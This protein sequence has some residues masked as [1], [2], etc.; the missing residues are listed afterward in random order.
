MT[1]NPNS[2]R[3]LTADELIAM[4]V[5][6]TGIGSI[7]WWSLNHRP[8]TV[9]NN[10]THSANLTVGDNNIVQTLPLTT[11]QA[12]AKIL[13]TGSQTT[14]VPAP[15]TII[16]NVPVAPAV[17]AAASGAAVDLEPPALAAPAAS[18]LPASV[19]PAMTAVLP[20]VLPSPTSSTPAFTD[21]PDQYWGKDYITILKERGVLE[22]FGSGKFDPN[23]PITRGEYAKMLDRAF[24]RPV[25]Q[26]VLE[27][28]DIPTTYPRRVALDKAVKMGF[29]SGYPK[30][31]FAPDE[32]IPRYQMQISLAKGMNLSV[33]SD[34]EA[35]LAKYPDAKDLPSYAR[36]KMGAAIASGFVVKDEQ[37]NKLQPVKAA[38][39]GEA[40]ALIY[41]ALVKDGKI[42]AGK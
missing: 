29:M 11:D 17:V 39:R 30:A 42:P 1:Q 41:E 23:A 21:V 34:A 16:N 38:T 35:M 15:T 14:V 4:L 3:R 37:N 27:F 32:K 18:P 8:V 12:P 2:R 7:Y 25:S 26:Q 28:K 31:K 19:I 22:D 36:P 24:D 6:I 33:P 40:A 10:P 20:S 9:V 5:A 13:P